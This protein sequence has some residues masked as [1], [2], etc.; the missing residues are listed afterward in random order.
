MEKAWKQLG[1]PSDFHNMR[2]ED[3]LTE[4]P[5]RELSAPEILFTKIG[6]KKIK[7]MEAILDKRIKI[8]M[9]KEKKHTEETKEEK[10]QISYEEFQKLDI[11]IGKVLSAENIKGSDKLLKLEVDIGEKRQ[12]VAGIAKSHSAADLVGRQVV[13]MANMKPAKLF[14]VESRGMVLAADAEETVLLL[15]AKEVKE[16][17]RVR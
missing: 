6:D 16:G 13:V 17:T 2:F 7:E 3:A 11:R 14:G 4:F 8:A 15:P 9:S 5:S 12:I 10:T 1:L